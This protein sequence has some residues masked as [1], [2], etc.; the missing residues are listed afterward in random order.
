MH[1]IV[2]GLLGRRKSGD[3]VGGRRLR[4]EDGGDVDRVGVGVVAAG[5]NRAQRRRV[6]IRVVGARVD[7]ADGG[8]DVRH[9]VG[10]QDHQLVGAF[11]SPAADAGRLQHG[12]A[13]ELVIGQH[14]PVARGGIAVVVA[15]CPR[16]LQSVGVP[17]R[18]SLS[19]YWAGTTRR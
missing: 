6:V 5:G 15:V 1:W 4:A 19:R 14:Q 16:S 11:A 2:T 13:A 9:S 8:G 7:R 3:R 18:T 10:F 12:T 17:G